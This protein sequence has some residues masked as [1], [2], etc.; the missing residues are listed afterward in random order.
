MS[1]HFSQIRANFGVLGEKA[2]ARVDRVG[3]GDLGGGDDRRDV[4]VALRRAA[5]ADAHRLVGEAHVE[6]A[7]VGLGV[8]GDGADAE[9]A[10]RA[11]DAQRDLA[12]VRDEDLLEQRALAQL[13]RDFEE[14]LAELDGLAVLGEDLDDRARALGLDLVH[15]LHRFDDAER[16][17]FADRAPTSTNGGASGDG[18]R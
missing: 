10:A 3:A 15:Q 17:A 4:E 12:A 2:V 16:L 13:L 1:R 8:H 9:L 18:E 14:L 6:R 7:R 11:D 5:R